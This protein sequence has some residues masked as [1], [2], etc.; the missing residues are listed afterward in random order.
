MSTEFDDGGERD[1]L[2][3]EPYVPEGND[4]ADDVRTT[5]PTAEEAH[6]RADEAMEKLCAD[7]PDIDACD[8]PVKDALWQVLV[9][10]WNRAVRQ[11]REACLDEVYW[12]PGVMRIDA[13][14]V[15]RERIRQ[16]GPR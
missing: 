2:A 6:R 16:R 1:E 5:E 9:D 12:T 15:I 3:L 8:G 10:L 7:V 13:I 14:K 4:R 11:E